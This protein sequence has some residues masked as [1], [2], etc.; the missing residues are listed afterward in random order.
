MQ[1]KEFSLS[2]DVKLLFSINTSY[3]KWKNSI[4]DI[5]H[6]GEYSK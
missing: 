5:K 2:I 1:R 6:I 4:R 3:E